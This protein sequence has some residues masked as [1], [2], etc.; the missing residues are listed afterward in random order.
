MVCVELCPLTAAILKVLA[1]LNKFIGGVHGRAFEDRNLGSLR[2]AC[3]LHA[4]GERILVRGVGRDA[5]R[6]LPHPRAE[7]VKARM[8]LVLA[9]GDRGSAVGCVWT[10]KSP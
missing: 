7:G 10:L 4:E 9:F 3:A 1:A 5:D 6:G 2:R 8:K